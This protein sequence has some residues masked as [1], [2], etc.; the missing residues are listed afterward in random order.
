MDQIDAPGWDGEFAVARYDRAASAWLILALHSTRLGPAAGGTRL[1]VYPDFRSALHDAFALSRSMTWKFAA[2]DVPRGGGKAVL[3]LSRPLTPE[4]REGLLMRYGT[5]VAE[6]GGRFYTGPD[7]GT[8]PLDMDVVAR[9]AG[10]FVHARTQRAGGAGDSGRWTA[11][12][13]HSAMRAACAA[14]FGSPSLRERRVLV[15]GAGSVGGTLIDLLLGEDA[16]VML[17]EIDPQAAAPWRDDARVRVVE[18]AA[19]LDTPCDVLAPCALGGVLDL[20]AVQRLRCRVVVGAA[21]NQL[22]HPQVAAALHAH[23]ILYAPDFVVN[24]GGAVAITGMEALGWSVAE[25]EAQVCRI[26]ERLSAVLGRARD[27]G[28]DLH[29]AALRAAADRL[30]IAPRETGN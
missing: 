16:Q 23:G 5:L 9:T 1:R 2:A 18:P 29:Q 25:A 3:A 13:V 12:G 27:E 21:N 7:V 6:L 22:A 19:M 11:L 28:I 4:Q 10:P 26:G 8:A 15:Q 24:S 14:A 17:C 20:H 30:R